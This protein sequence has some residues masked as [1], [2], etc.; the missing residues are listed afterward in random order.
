METVTLP[1]TPTCAVGKRRKNV[2]LKT[3]AR[4][5]KIFRFQRIFG[6]LGPGKFVVVA[7]DGHSVV[8]GSDNFL[9]RVHDTG[10]DLRHRI[11]AAFG[12]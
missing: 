5:V 6:V 12:D 3:G 2:F 7:T 1:L 10:A 11:F 9:I 8:T 4:T